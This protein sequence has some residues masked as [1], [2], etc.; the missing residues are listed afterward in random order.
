MRAA[1]RKSALA[2][3]DAFS[4]APLVREVAVRAVIGQ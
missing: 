4:I 2:A 1:I 3:R